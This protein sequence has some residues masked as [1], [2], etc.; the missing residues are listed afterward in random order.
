[1]FISFSDLTACLRAIIF[2]FGDDGLG[3]NYEEYAGKGQAAVNH[4]LETKDCKW[5]KRSFFKK[6]MAWRKKKY[7]CYS[8]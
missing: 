1:M 2:N 6:R 4:L 8:F 3:H 5:Y 7:N